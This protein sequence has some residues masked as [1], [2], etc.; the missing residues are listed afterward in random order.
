MN[1]RLLLRRMQ[2]T[3]NPF[4]NSLYAFSLR[5]LGLG[6][7]NIIEVRRSSDNATQNFTAIEIIDGTLESF[8]GALNDG[9]VSKWYNQNNSNFIQQL[10]PTN[11]PKIVSN[12]I[13]ILLNGQPALDFDGVNDFFQ[14][15]QHTPTL[16]ETSFIWV[17]EISGGDNI[18]FSGFSQ[19][20]QLF[21]SGSIEIAFNN[22]NTL[23][24]GNKS[25]IETQSILWGN[26]IGLNSNFYVNN[27][28]IQTGDP[29]NL[30]FDG[31]TFGG[32]EGSGSA[33]A[34]QKVNEFIIYPLNND[35]NR[36]SLMT[37]INNYYNI[38]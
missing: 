20:Y 5:D 37:N 2:A 7:A 19:N 18:L 28:L 31:L 23:V 11:Q 8:V 9:F 29:G 12:G 24:L 38:Y 26:V 25:L 17:G 36:N 13:L 15:I 34:Q 16:Y 32:N 33:R 1:N 27:S 14:P 4:E 10:T 3:V 6:S 30:G 35:T 22:G 21:K